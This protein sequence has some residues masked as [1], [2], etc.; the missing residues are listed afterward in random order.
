MLHNTVSIRILKDLCQTKGNPWFKKA[1]EFHRTPSRVAYTAL[2]GTGGPY[3]FLEKSG[4]GGDY[5]VIR[6]PRES[7]YL[8]ELKRFASRHAARRYAIKMAL[9]SDNSQV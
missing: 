2:K 8:Y 9:T 1:K 3:F 6:M 5:H 7:Y 4:I